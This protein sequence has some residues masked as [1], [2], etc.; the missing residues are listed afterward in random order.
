VM[1]PTKLREMLMQHSALGASAGAGLLLAYS[2][3]ES[4]PRLV[5]ET[6]RGWGPMSLLCVIA[7]VMID[8]G[9]RG[10]VGAVKESSTAQQRLADAVNSIAQRDNYEAEQQKILLGHIGTTMEKVLIKLES[11]E[12]NSKT[13]GASA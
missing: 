1:F 9:F 8:R 2:L 10:M 3:I 7:L 12:P 6:F 13:R 4:E 11:M 5:I